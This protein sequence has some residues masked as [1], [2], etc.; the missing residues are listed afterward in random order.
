VE[1]V[2]PAL[3]RDGIGLFLLGSAIVVGAAVWWGLPGVVGHAIF[4]GVASLIGTLC[5]VAPSAATAD[6]LANTAASPTAM[7]RSDG[8]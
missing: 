2:D 6:G 4:I 7:V 8:S 5:Y 1:E 3:R